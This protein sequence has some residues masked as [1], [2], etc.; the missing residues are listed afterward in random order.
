MRLAHATVLIA[1]IAATPVRAEVAELTIAQQFGVS[2]LPLMMMERDG[3]IEKRAR[4]LG[5]EN[6]KINWP[7]LAG[8]K[9]GSSCCFQYDHRYSTGLSS[10]A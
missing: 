5:I 9:L 4:A 8:Q 10:G 2:F 3:A 1:L 6:L 7:K